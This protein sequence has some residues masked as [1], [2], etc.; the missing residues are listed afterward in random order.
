MIHWPEIEHHIASD[1][2]RLCDAEA[3]SESDVSSLGQGDIRHALGAATL[4][5]DCQNHSGLRP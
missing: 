1:G 4:C 3:A 5:P 2:R